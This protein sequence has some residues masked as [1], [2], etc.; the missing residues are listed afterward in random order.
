[1]C[2]LQVNQIIETGLKTDH[3]YKLLLYHE[4]PLKVSCMPLRHIPMAYL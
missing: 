2:L 3:V 1:M 4:T